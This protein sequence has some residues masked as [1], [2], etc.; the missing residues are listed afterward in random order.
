VAGPVSYYSPRHRNH[1][2]QEMNAEKTL[3]DVASIICQGLADIA[4]HIIGYRLP[5]GTRVNDT[6]YDVAGNIWQTIWRGWTR[7]SSRGWP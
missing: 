1:L 6:L 2:T 5:Q 4:R 7:R 3:D